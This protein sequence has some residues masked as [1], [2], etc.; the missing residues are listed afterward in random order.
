MK[1]NSINLIRSDKDLYAHLKSLLFSPFANL[2]LFI[3]KSNKIVKIIFFKLFNPLGRRILNLNYARNKIYMRRLRLN[4]EYLL[5]YFDSVSD[6]VNYSS[7]QWEDCLKET[8]WVPKPSKG[9]EQK[10]KILNK[11]S[12]SEI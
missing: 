7:W 10:K 11:F 3:I 12:K 2:F 1:F 5:K 8:G 6:T 4:A 9:P